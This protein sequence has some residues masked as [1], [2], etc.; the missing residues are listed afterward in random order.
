V[1]AFCKIKRHGGLK[2]KKMGLFAVIG[3]LA[4]VSMGCDTGSNDESNSSFKLQS[5]AFNNNQ[6]LD[7]KYCYNGVTGGQN[8]SLPFSWVQP[9]ED[10]QSFALIIY[11]PDGGNWI[12]WAVFNIPASSNAIA[13]NA[14]GSSMPSGSVELDNEF[15][16]SGYGG[17]EPP[18]GSGTH[19][20]IATLYALNTS[21]VNINGFKNY[22]GLKAVL[23]GKII[24]TASITG[25]YSR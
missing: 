19:R 24:D 1:Y 21:T 4:F 18:A 7:V 22:T 2:M 11:D 20:Y 10:T 3:I 6:R 17:P 8:I 15:G 25:T 12:H 23:Q 16:T 14:S 9:P 13:E 5:S